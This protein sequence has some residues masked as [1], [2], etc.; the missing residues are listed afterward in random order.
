MMPACIGNTALMTTAGACS[1]TCSSDIKGYAVTAW[2]SKKTLTPIGISKDGH[3]IYGPY[4]A[5]GNLWKACDVDVCNGL[6]INSRYAYVATNFHPYFVGCF[7]P[8][9]KPTVSQTCSTNP[10]SCSSA[11]N[12]LTLGL[13]SAIILLSAWFY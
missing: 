8:G 10:R 6:L 3:I 7:G 5:S 4:D 13:F 9:N 2:S 12:S 1:G 11:V